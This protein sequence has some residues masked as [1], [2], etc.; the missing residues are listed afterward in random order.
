MYHRPSDHI[1]Y[2]IECLS[3][4]KD[5][6]QENLA[7][8]SFVEAKRTKTPLPPITPDNGKRPKSR[9]KTPVK[10]G[11]ALWISLLCSFLNKLIII[12]NIGFV[13]SKIRKNQLKTKHNF[14]SLCLD[15]KTF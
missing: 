2:L 1:S 10:I 15:T 9:T 14:F 3:K 4:V 5:K 6:G 7:W 12:C 13:Q 8:N 11:N